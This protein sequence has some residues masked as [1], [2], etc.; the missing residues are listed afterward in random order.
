M[1][2]MKTINVRELRNAMPHLRE[3]LAQEQELLLVSHGAV[4]FVV[5][6]ALK[7]KVRPAA[8]GVPLAPSSPQ[9]EYRR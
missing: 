4:Q 5:Y 3:T 6:E 7:T 2:H 1:C 9:C 8:F